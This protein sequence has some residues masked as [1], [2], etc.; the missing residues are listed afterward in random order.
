MVTRLSISGPVDLADAREL[1]HGL[2]SGES[3]EKLRLLSSFW[4][5]SLMGLVLLGSGVGGELVSSWCRVG[6]C[7]RS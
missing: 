5:G 4:S 6:V 3:S 1:R 7:V 2:G